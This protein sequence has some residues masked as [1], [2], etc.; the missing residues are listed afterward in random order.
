MY[1][2]SIFRND[3]LYIV[4]NIIIINIMYKKYIENLLFGYNIIEI[5]I[6]NSR[7][8]VLFIILKNKLIKFCKCHL[9]KNN[10]K[11]TSPYA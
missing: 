5:K 10:Q 3:N 11:I 6:M 4:I 2:D 8:R 9:L 1:H 7:N